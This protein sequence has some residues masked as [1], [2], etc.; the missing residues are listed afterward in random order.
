MFGFVCVRV[1]VYCS[2]FF[3]FCSIKKKKKRKKTFHMLEMNNFSLRTSLLFGFSRL[4]QQP[5]NSIKI[6]LQYIEPAINI[7]N[8]TQI[9]MTKSHARFIISICMFSHLRWNKIVT[10]LYEKKLLQHEKKK[11]KNHT[12][13]ENNINLLSIFSHSFL[14]TLVFL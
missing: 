6:I 3:E 1:C 2:Q 9:Q 14:I 4:R 10:K 13:Y 11:E 7:D 12:L 8:K 5:Q